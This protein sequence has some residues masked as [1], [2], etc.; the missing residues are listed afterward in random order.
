MEQAPA[1]KAFANYL[2]G[3]AY[4]RGDMTIPRFLS[5]TA[6]FATRKLAEALNLQMTGG[7]TSI[8][9]TGAE[10]FRRVGAAMR[11]LLVTAAAAEWNVP[12]S[13]IE[14]KDSK[15]SHKGSGKSATYGEMAAKAASFEFAGEP[16]LKTRDRY[17]IMGMSKPRFDVPAKVTGEARYGHDV[18]LPGLSFAVFK[19]APD[20]GGTLA[21]V[22]EAPALKMRGV[23]KVV[24]LADAVAVVADNTWRAQ[25]ALAALD[26]KWAK[27]P[28]AGV[29]TDSIF[30]A[31]NAA[32]DKGE[33][34]TEAS[35]G[36]A[37]AR[38]AAAPVKVEAAYSVPFLAHACM[39][40]V[41][42]T[43]W[44][45]KGR[46]RVWAAIQDGL[47][48]R[49]AAAKAAGLSIDDV[50]FNHAAM[51]GGFGRKGQS[52]YI[53]RAV[54]VA[55]EVDGPVQVLF[56]R[57]A[58]MRGGAYRNP[59][60][61]RMKAGLDES[62]R[63][64]AWM[65]DFTERHDPPDATWVAYGIADKAT[66][67]VNG[68]N[69]I[70]WCAWRSVDHTMHGF[71]IESFVDE[72]AHAAK[73]DPL[74][75][76]LKHLGNSPRHAAVLEAAAQMAGWGQKRAEGRALGI[77]MRESF[78][79]I[80]AQVAEVS[81]KGDGTVKVHAIWSAADP[82]E[83][84]DPRNFAAQ[85]EGG[86]IYGLCAALYGEITIKDGGAVEGNFD[87][88][89]IAR[90]EDAPRQEVKIIESGARQ[91]GAGEP[92]TA[93]VTAA[94]ANAVFA[95]TGQ[96]IRELPLKNFDLRTGAKLARL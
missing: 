21:G 18:R 45:D 82:G 34:E 56:T 8:R 9:L 73:E 66:R 27:G 30:A 64:T 75:F 14:A 60:V 58:D 59:A 72:A 5:G 17:T 26:I 71:F 28:N 93:P 29:S 32:L 52:D 12:E 62:G 86:A 25:Q 91:G 31:M 79:T 41:N 4:L 20:F 95:L 43:A 85:I 65:H 94:I 7:S 53:E 87:T 76:R 69:P 38:F 22:D 10:G 77:S 50:E 35:E 88:Y 46:L 84:V 89:R 83:V 90:M 54:S 61:A 37:P 81:V 3:R 67:Y 55:R 42:T 74:A 80:V 33:M 40:T 57:E 92:G 63:I 24:K 19:A 15:L 36:D 2:L 39:E 1:D 44:F 96:R 68:N 47:G 78:G 51:G 49:A 23:K 6:D 16:A 11:G 48:A 70:P 13:E